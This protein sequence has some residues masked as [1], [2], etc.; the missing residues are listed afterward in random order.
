MIWVVRKDINNE[1]MLGLDK[2][3][4]RRKQMIEVIKRRLERKEY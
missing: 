4:S 1:E 2:Y 3:L